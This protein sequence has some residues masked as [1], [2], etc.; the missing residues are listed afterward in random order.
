MST[1]GSLFTTAIAII[2]V[3]METPGLLHGDE[4]SELSRNTSWQ[5]VSD[6]VWAI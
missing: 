4:D 3:V 5:H 2:V 1:A 6:G